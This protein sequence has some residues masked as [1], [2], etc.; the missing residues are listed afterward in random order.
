MPGISKEEAQLIPGSKPQPPAIILIW[1]GLHAQKGF[2][3]EAIGTYQKTIVEITTLHTTESSAHLEEIE[4]M[5]LKSARKLL[6][7]MAELA[8]SVQPDMVEPP[9]TSKPVTPDN[10][11]KT[12]E[13]CD[14]RS[15]KVFEILS[16][17]WTQAGGTVQCAK[18]GRIYLRLK[19]KAHKNGTIARLPRNFNLVVLAAPKGKTP[20]KIQVSWD[21]AADVDFAYLDCIPEEVVQFERTV[22]NLPGFEKKGTIV[23]LVIGPGFKDEHTQSLLKAMLSIKAAEKNAD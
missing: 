13:L 6:K 4:T 10:L 9:T 21:L 16:D 2:P 5:D 20:A 23:S 8:K 22:F 17:G 1:E 12:L 14:A 3:T 19:T 7:A 18:V 11:A 15:K